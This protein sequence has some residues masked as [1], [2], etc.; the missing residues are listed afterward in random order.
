MAFRFKPPKCEDVDGPTYW[1]NGLLIAI[2]SLAFTLRRTDFKTKNRR[3][4]NCFNSV[5]NS[6]SDT[7]D[8]TKQLIN[9]NIR[10]EE[11]DDGPFP[12]EEAIRLASTK[13]KTYKQKNKSV[14]EHITLLVRPHRVL[15]DYN[16]FLVRPCGSQTRP[17]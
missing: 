1:Q 17:I 13:N 9:F 5:K 8:N 2:I 3:S 14:V 11:Q 4:R 15:E 12:G 6:N 16:A 10:H 7:N